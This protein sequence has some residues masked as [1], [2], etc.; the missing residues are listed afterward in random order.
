MHTSVDHKDFCNVI[1]LYLYDLSGSYEAEPRTR[2]ESDAA[3]KPRG[4]SASRVVRSNKT[5]SADVSD[6]YYQDV[7]DETIQRRRSPRTQDTARYVGCNDSPDTAYRIARESR[8]WT[9]SME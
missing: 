3:Y 8:S 1:S 7:P 2:A 4:S 6:V 9:G 5:R